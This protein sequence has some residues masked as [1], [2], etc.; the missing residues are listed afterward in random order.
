[1]AT[2]SRRARSIALLGPNFICLVLYHVDFIALYAII[3]SSR[4]VSVNSFLPSSL[5]QAPLSIN[6]LIMT[7]GVSVADEL[8]LK[9]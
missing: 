3:I 9:A 7:A 1:M 2:R 8:C 5:R 6:H 4:F